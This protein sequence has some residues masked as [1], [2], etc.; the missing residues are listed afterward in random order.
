MPMEEVTSL[1]KLIGEY[2][3]L[4]VIAAVLIIVFV[5]NSKKQQ[6]HYSEM[7][8]SQA[9]SNKTMIESVLSQNKILIENYKTAVKELR[10]VPATYNEKNIVEIFVKLNDI[11]KVECQTTSRNTKS[12][13]TSVYV[14]H[15]GTH[16]S[17]G[18][19][20]FKMSCICEW[21]NKGA[22]SN[23]KLS[24]HTNMT[25]NLF[26]PIVTNLYKNGEFVINSEQETEPSNLLF[27]KGTKIQTIIFI[28][29]Y[30]DD[31][32]IMGFVANDY[33]SKTPLNFEEIKAE[34]QLLCDKVKPVLEF[35][36]YQDIA[37][38]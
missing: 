23:T 12:D 13:R 35:S 16:S 6:K 24:E 1:V 11:L 14:F 30:D 2:G 22:A 33:N 4:V 28:A 19:P 25:L 20:F 3:V 38:E 26:D 9:E 5:Y 15:N 32:N 21:I 29:I 8:K 36:N 10:E 37:K 34:M 7:A 27:I 17:H 31:N 18:M